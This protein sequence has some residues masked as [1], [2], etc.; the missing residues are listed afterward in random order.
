MLSTDLRQVK[1]EGRDSYRNLEE[2]I[3]CLNHLAFLVFLLFP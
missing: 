1:A 3:C 2:S